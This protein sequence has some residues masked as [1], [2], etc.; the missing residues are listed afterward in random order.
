MRRP[1][2]HSVVGMTIVSLTVVVSAAR[3]FSAQPQDALAF[4]VVS[5]KPSNAGDDRTS[6]I[7]QPG[8]RYTAN[9]VTLRALMK[10][11]YGVHDDQIVGGPEWIDTARF[12]VSAKANVDNPSATTF[13]DRA[14]LML[15]AALAD[16]FNL[17]LRKETREIPVYALVLVREDGRLGPQ[18]SRS[19]AVECNGPPKA[20]PTAPGAAEPTPPFPCGAGFSR[21]AHV[22]ARGV[23][24]ST[25]VTNVSSWADRIVVDR[26]G[27]TGKF[28]WDLQWTPESLTPGS[29]PSGVSLVTALREQLG[30]R[31]ESQRG[32]IEVLVVDHVERPGPD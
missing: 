25:L 32:M 3:P 26:T 4:D 14:R 5:V 10:T 31:L 12:D 1:N 29:V 13:R 9:N 11:A 16:R 19:E 2:V 23:E 24:F 30:L 7:V 8:G 22:A 18:L 28:D 20:V 15:R 17:V 21:P 6:S 27:L